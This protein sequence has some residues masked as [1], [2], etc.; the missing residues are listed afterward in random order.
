MLSQ[1]LSQY[2]APDL[3]PI[4]TGY[5]STIGQCTDKF[6]PGVGCITHLV[7]LSNGSVGVGGSNGLVFHNTETQTIDR[8][9]SSPTLGLV[10]YN[11]ILVS[12]HDQL[13]EAWGVRQH[14]LQLTIELFTLYNGHPTVGSGN[15]LYQLNVI[16]GHMTYCTLN[17]DLAKNV[18]VL[19]NKYITKDQ[20]TSF[21]PKFWPIQRPVEPTCVIGKNKSIVMGYADGMVLATGLPS[22]YI[23]WHGRHSQ[24]VNTLIWL[25]D[26]RIA[27]GSDDG[28]IHVW[29]YDGTYITLSH[30]API[31]C[32]GLL[33]DGRLIAGSQDHSI[34]V[35]E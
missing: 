12:A 11:N 6:D 3:I 15:T 31:K 26:G 16:T 14:T 20:L 2:I 22:R 34:T 25:P 29:S 24:R 8:L 13:I 18:F 17:N 5:V 30:T 21:R 23:L 33:N 1:I 27:S 9:T 35:W 32:L 10:G 7:T 4:I 28:T 19:D